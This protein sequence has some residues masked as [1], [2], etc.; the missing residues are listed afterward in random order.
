M[1]DPAAAPAAPA[2]PDGAPD[3]AVEPDVALAVALEAARIAVE[4]FHGTPTG[5]VRTKA[6]A[7][8]PVT[9]VDLATERAVRE[10]LAA[11][12]PGHAV[13][14]EELG[15]SEQAG[16]TWY[17]DPVDGTTNLAAGIPWS[18][19]SLALAVGRTPLVGVVADP[20]RDE[21]LHA[22]RGGGAFRR[23]VSGGQE[24]D[25]PVRVSGA[26]TLAGSV[27]LTEWAAHAPWPGMTRLLARL[28][29]QLCTTR[30]M[31]SGTLAVASVG[32]GRAAGAVIGQFQPE[33]HLAAVLIC[34][35]AGALVT[36]VF[37]LE[38]A[39]PGGGPFL[40]AAPGV[41]ARLGEELS[42]AFIG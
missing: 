9:D 32:A 37:G 31:G 10:H 18:S 5:K 11:A 28:G 33:D 36:D 21:V 40:A 2:V 26:E 14:G 13:V 27:I 15:G 17:C 7:A 30:I 16:P 6:H 25:R 38:T 29:E 24:P 20:W 19:F 39:W 22:V 34:R 42:T 8:D 12:F 41:A 4:V 35:E 3:I 1:P 23:R